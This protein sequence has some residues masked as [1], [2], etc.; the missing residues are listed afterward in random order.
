ML[1]PKIRLPGSG[2]ACE[3][4]INAQ[5]IL[6]IMRLS[7]RAFVDKLDFMTSGG[8]LSG[9]GRREALGMPGAG[10]DLVIT[11]K[12]LFSFDNPQR[13]MMLIELAP[14]ETV[15][16]IQAEVGWPLRVADE[17]RIM[18]PPLPA[19]LVIIREQ[20]DPDGLYR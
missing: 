14:G 15:E 13:E 6:M 8:H 3:I 11:D 16:S 20:L 9:P 18:R 19:E 7:K 1:H 5:R 2:G 17:V 12:A 10:P 4:A